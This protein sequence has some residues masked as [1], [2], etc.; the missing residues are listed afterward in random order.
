MPDRPPRLAVVTSHPIQYQVPLWRALA[1]DSRVDPHVFYLSRHGLERRTDRDF[2]AAFAW[3][4][5]LLDGYESSFV[6]NLRERTPPGRFLSHINPGIGRALGRHRPHAVLFS[7]LRNPSALAALLRARSKR[8]PCLY[9]SESSV[10]DPHGGVALRSGA[11]L[12]HRTQ[13]VLPIGTANDR[14]YDRIGY[15]PGR[16]FLS[17]YA[18]DNRHFRA[19]AVEQVAARAGLGLPGE[20]SSCSTAESSSRGRTRW[21]L[22]AR[23]RRCRPRVPCAS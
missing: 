7:G 1:D 14:Y 13:A 3:D 9:R 17:P 19:S 22:Y 6:R 4:I 18:V 23:A 21:W 5:D 15:P 16:R 12:I 2:G 10:L 20:D 8:I 11:W